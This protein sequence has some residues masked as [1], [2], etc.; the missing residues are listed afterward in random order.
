MTKKKTYNFIDLFAGCGGLT[1]GFYKEG[2]KPL[3]HVEFEHH[4]CETLK[5][6][7]KHY[8]YSE[9]TIQK[10]VLEQDITVRNINSI[11]E[12]VVG[13]NEVDLIIGGPPC[14]A[15]SSSGK[16]RDENGMKEDP[17]NFLFEKYVK[18]LNK[19]KPKILVFENVTGLLTT[20]I[21][22]VKIV[23]LVFKALGEKYNIVTDPKTIVFNMANYGVPQV[24]KRVIIIGVRKDLKL[25]AQSIYDKLGKTHFDPEM[26]LEERKG[27]KHY[28]TVRDA[29][30][31][32][33]HIN[34]GE[35]RKVQPYTPQINNDFIRWV[36]AEDEHEIHDHI[37]RTQNKIDT[38]RYQLMANNGWTFKELRKQRP[39]LEHEHARVFSNSYCVQVWD[40]PSRTMLAHLCKDGN[41]FIHPDG[42]Q[43]RSISVRESAR[44]QAFPDD[45]EFYGA[46]SQQFKQIGNA[47]PPLFANIIAKSILRTL[48]ENN[49]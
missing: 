34:A 19:F 20:V 39:D 5:L 44:F 11:I 17:R 46:M 41:S 10:A 22:K 24:R 36:C 37:T 49:L 7:M 27:L 9:D 26:K 38:L 47:V 13:G 43:G 18:V 42:A 23:D 45:F 14:Q 21:D 40:L 48:R 12:K 8:S 25:S 28:V 32:L 3:A 29:I 2:F 6:R 35:K 33:P 16:A 1:E 4:C 31:D 15:Y 30:G